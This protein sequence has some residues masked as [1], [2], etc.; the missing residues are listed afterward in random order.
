M[1]LRSQIKH[2]ILKQTKNNN[3]R[4]NFFEKIKNIYSKEKERKQEIAEEEFTSTNLILPRDFRFLEIL[5]PKW[6]VM[7]SM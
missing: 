5:E 6:F 1:R 4:T 2:F 3:F 7:R